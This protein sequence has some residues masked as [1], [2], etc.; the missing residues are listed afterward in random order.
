MTEFVIGETYAFNVAMEH[1]DPN[2]VQGKLIAYNPVHDT[3]TVEW[4]DG[5]DTVDAWTVEELRDWNSRA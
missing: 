3:Y 5:L 2:I 1:C 4:S